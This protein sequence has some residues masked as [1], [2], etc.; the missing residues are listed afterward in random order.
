LLA[1]GTAF[2]AP[3]LKPLDAEPGGFHLRGA[4]SLGKSTAML[5]AASVW[6]GHDRLKRWRSTD[7][8]LEATALEHNDALLLLDELREADPKTLGASIYMLAHGNGKVRLSRDA[9]ARPSLNWRVMLLSTG[10]IGLADH[11]ES[12][13]GRF[14]AGQ[15]ARI[16]D[17]PADAGQGFGLFDSLH[18]FPDGGTLARH[19][20]KA[21]K[22]HHG[23]AI[24]AFIERLAKGR[25]S[26]KARW[27]KAREP[28]VNALIQKPEAA[29]MVYRVANRFALCAFA[30]E[31]ASEWGI[32]GW[33]L[34]EATT[35]IAS[36][37]NAW[38]SARGGYGASEDMEA[39]RAVRD[40]LQAHADAR[41]VPLD[42]ADEKQLRTIHRAGAI[43]F[44]NGQALYYL[45]TGPFR[46]EVCK[47][48]DHLAVARILKERGH[49][50][51]NERDRLTI[52]TPQLPDGSRPRA[53][54]IKAS[55]LE[56]DILA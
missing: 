1:L 35:G 9:T 40:F 15:E 27:E 25:E 7:N 33:P 2:A 23:H 19:L 14:H 12:A 44:N 39:L 52:K 17:I 13:G 48:L 36:S 29:G 50:V 11:V 6:G 47:S 4:S 31:L 56:D 5:V 21:T 20:A 45:F 10:E 22:D 18:D 16:T 49:L 54:C 53:Y 34:G 28:L 3:L 46:N 24:H 55:I 43:D 42:I 37:F 41:L 51:T 32:T 26:V 38:L 8:A 30:A